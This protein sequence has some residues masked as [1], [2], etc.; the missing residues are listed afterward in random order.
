M[1]YAKE[2]VEGAEGVVGDDHA[3]F[4]QAGVASADIIQLS[5][6]PH[7]HTPEDTLDKIS[8]LSLKAV[9]D[10]VIAS[11]PRIE[12]KLE[13]KTGRLRD[14]ET[15]RPEDAVCETNEASDINA[16][17]LSTCLSIPSSPRPRSR[18]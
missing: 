10:A 9:G 5:S 17:V 6:Y 4:L 15:G 14:R 18:R 13:G 12:K 3:A 11:L 1:G 16:E 2:F 8:P 7:W